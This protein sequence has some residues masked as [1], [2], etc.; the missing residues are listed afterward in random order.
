MNY[1]TMLDIREKKQLSKLNVNRGN[2][3]AVKSRIKQTLWN[4]GNL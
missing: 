1:R 2:N 4:C 3:S